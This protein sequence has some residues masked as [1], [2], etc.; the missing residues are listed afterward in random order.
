MQ[1][2]GEFFRS[3][4]LSAAGMLVATLPNTQD[5]WIAWKVWTP[6][7]ELQGSK[8]NTETA[9]TMEHPS[10][11][12]STSVLALAAHPW[13]NHCLSAKTGMSLRKWSLDVCLI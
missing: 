12:R 13:Y 9:A 5:L 7:L 1:D 2:L 3:T 10:P 8:G 6:V 4:S 11:R